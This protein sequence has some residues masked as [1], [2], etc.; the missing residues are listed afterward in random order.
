MLQTS[1]PLARNADCIFSIDDALRASPCKRT[2]WPALEGASDAVSV[3]AS[4][5]TNT[6]HAIISAW[7]AIRMGDI[8]AA[9][10]TAEQPKKEIALLAVKQKRALS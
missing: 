8:V 6:P 2:T 1:Y 5:A 4:T 9:L 7:I 10:A 3:P